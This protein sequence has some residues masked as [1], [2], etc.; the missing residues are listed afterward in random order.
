MAAS[1]TRQRFNM[2]ILGVFSGVALV[3]AAVGIYGVVSYS[4][5]QR[6][7]EIGIRMALGAESG[8]VLKM[9]V[10]EG[11][12]LAVIG[13]AIGVV[14][15]FGLTRFM[16]SLLFGVG[17]TDAFTFIAVAVFLTGVT[18]FA[19]YIPARRAAK[20]DPIVALRYE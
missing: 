18:A 10:K 7:H 5:T 17:V 1:L 4:V 19:S 14:A 20:V 3:L 16:A 2:I 15:A 13:V 9:V 12:V 6:S 8:H 11:L